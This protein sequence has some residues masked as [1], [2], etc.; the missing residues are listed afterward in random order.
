MPMQHKGPATFVIEATLH[1]QS[2]HDANK[3]VLAAVRP[4]TMASLV[5]LSHTYGKHTLQH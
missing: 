4:I 2:R 1:T 3:E 5:L